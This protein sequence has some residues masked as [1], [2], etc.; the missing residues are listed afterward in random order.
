MLPVY[1]TS[2]IRGKTKVYDAHEYFSQQKEIVT[3]AKI[4]RFWHFIEKTFVPK[5]KNGYTVSEGIANAFRKNY[6]VEYTII[7]VITI[8]SII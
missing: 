1:F 7:L 8:Q 6:D 2:L 5:F 3:R 4:Y